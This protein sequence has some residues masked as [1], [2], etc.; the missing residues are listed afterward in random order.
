MSFS[1]CSCDES[2]ED[3]MGRTYSINGEMVKAYKILV[4]KISCE[5]P[6]GRPRHNWED[7][8]EMEL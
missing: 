4:R 1:S 3:E 2:K 8:I 5:G 7:D 6:L